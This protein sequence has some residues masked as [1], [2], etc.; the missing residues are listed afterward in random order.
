MKDVPHICKTCR[1]ANWQLRKDGKPNHARV[2]RCR[3]V[4]Q[5]PAVPQVMERDVSH[6]VEL[7]CRNIWYF[8]KSPCRVWEGKE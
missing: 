8:D 6:A 4:F 1:L 3:W 7:G 5:E 2:G